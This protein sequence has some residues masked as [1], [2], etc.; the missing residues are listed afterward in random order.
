M[1]LFVDRISEIEWNK[2]AFESLV[3]NEKTKE[4]VQALITNQLAAEKSTDLITGKG[5]GLTIL[6][7]GG[8]GTGKTF[9]AEGVAEIAE[10]PLYRV[11]RG[12]VG[13]K[14]EEVEKYLESALN[15][16]KIWDCGEPFP[17]LSSFFRIP[18]CTQRSSAKTRKV[19][20]LDEADVFL[21][22]RGL[23]DLQRNA[24]VSVFLRVLE[25][26]VGIL[27]LTSTRVGT[28]DEAFKSRIQLTLRYKNLTA[29]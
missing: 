4:L 22:E 16:G 20:L 6:L 24:L 1:D 29:S 3:V 8:P 17:L 26:N 12:D 10:K 11:T 25:Y 5:N 2:Q 7:H 15:L 23:A 27:I 21:E 19:V 18:P 28:F 9:T 14:P 13:T